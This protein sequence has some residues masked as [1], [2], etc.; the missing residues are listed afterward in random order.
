MTEDDRS[1]EAVRA[2]FPQ[3]VNALRWLTLIVITLLI[4]AGFLNMVRPF[5]IALVMA[6]ISAALAAPLFE[7]TNALLKGR[8]MLASTVTMLIVAV[9]ILLPLLGI[10][11]M[12]SQQAAGV[13]SSVV[14][15]LNEVAADPQAVTLPDWLPGWVIAP[16]TMNEILPRLRDA[17][18]SIASAV[19]GFLVSSIS[20]VTR[21]TASFVLS[22]FIYLYAM[23]FFLQ[24]KT[25]I[26]RV[27]LAYTGLRPDVQALLWERVVS[28]SRATVK[29]TL[30][31]GVVQGALGGLGFW[32]AGIE[33]AAFWAVV[34]AVF[35]VVPGIG[36]TL[37]IFFG[38]I[39]LLATGATG[40]AVGL[41]IWG[42][43]VVGTVDNLLRPALV[44]RDAKMHDILILVST[45]GGL[46][47]FG[48]VGLVLGPVLAGLF[49][50]I[51]T[52][53]AEVVG[54]EEAASESEPAAASDQG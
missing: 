21:S 50:A 19:T 47:T 29:G 54:Y 6:A 28:V 31:I 23:F 18:A 34:M 41:G 52:T 27:L 48:A 11:A 39:Y 37:I 49:V 38:V 15:L 53:L 22:G 44:G 16:D 8:R 17:A 40:A 12:A 4:T 2:H 36:P 20:A 32:V 24:M 30:L 26:A 13:A 46:V 9:I 3:T 33:G 7:R 5:L 42:A 51:W 43:G 14:R 35:S 25:P 45:L 1:P 10:I